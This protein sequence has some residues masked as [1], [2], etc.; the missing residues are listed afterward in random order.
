MSAE[1]PDT[2]VPILVLSL[3][4]DPR[5][6]GPLHIARS[7]GRLGIRVY[8]VQSSRLAPAVSSRYMCGTLVV[9]HEASTAEWLH[10]L[11]RI[12]AKLG[13]AVLI[14]IDDAG[15]AFV[16]EHADTLADRFLFPRRPSELNTLLGSKRELHLLATRL[17]IG[18]PDAA[19]P[20]D[21]AEASEDA[22]RLG[23]P[24]V[25]KRVVGWPPSDDDGM[26][27]VRIARDREELR[28][29]FTE[30]RGTGAQPNVM[31]Q[32]HIP[33]APQSVCMFNGYFDARSEA[34]VR[35]TG[36]KVRQRPPYTGATTLG[37]CAW[38]ERVDRDSRRLLGAVDYRGIVDLG[39]RYD[40][41]DGRYK[42]LDVNP[43]IGATFRLFVGDDGMDVLRAL[44][45][46]LTGQHVAPTRQPEGRRWIVEHADVSS[47]ISYWRDGQ[48]TPREWLDSLAGVRETA[49]FAA[50]D[51]IPALAM[52]AT[53]SGDGISRRFRRMLRERE[54]SSLELRDPVD[55]TTQK[56][57]E[58]EIHLG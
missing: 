58:E 1:T 17:G 39:F 5:H 52:L 48:L 21:V 26:V 3:A 29:M 12:G 6:H 23:Y 51:P 28:R 37:V 47:S 25:L 2:S 15:T 20:Q 7:A 27:S 50:D 14:P 16:D 9:P 11:D 42:L 10:N 18:S 41:R 13:R 4:P 24:V 36:L 35:F 43:R 54:A 33:G 8:S 32:E 45:L 22:E 34:L 55:G 38:N 44:Y 46:D 56:G 31:L 53:I 30:M 40:A 49:W 57:E 19:F